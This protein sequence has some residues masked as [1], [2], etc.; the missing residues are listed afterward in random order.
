MRILAI[1][2]GAGTQDILLY[3]SRRREENNLKLILPSPVQILA[4]KIR[5][6]RKES[7]LV[8]GTTMGGGVF[9]LA[10]LEKIKEGKKVFITEKAARS[11]RDDIDELKNFGFRIISSEEAEEIEKKRSNDICVIEAKDV[12]FDYIFN[13]LKKINEESFDFIGIAVQD[14]GFEKGKSD[15]ITRFS[16]IKEMLE[17]ENSLSSFLFSPPPQIFT[18]MRANYEYLKEKLEEKKIDARVFIV[19][20]KIAAIAG[21]LHGVKERPCM[22]FDIGNA[23]TMCAIV[24][25]K[26]SIAGIFEH[27]TALL[28][29]EKIEKFATKLALGRLS[30][31]EI[32]SDDGHGAYSIEN[33]GGITGIK[34][35]L[36]TG[37]KREL[38]KGASLNF[39][40]A[41]P[42]GDIMLS[43]AVGIVDLIKEKCQE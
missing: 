5:K 28:S 13:F 36:V 22:V 39:S 21:A 14:H 35:I 30:N 34:K 29:R 25:N 16:K 40:Y 33:A 41:M 15:R 27:H 7:I 11:I 2:I 12:D 23:H 26:F 9:A 1:D 6:C 19:D 17:K 38:I 43:G 42:F 37:P 18:R 4:S 3:D 31:E 20:T 8:K 24:K 32:Y 10:L